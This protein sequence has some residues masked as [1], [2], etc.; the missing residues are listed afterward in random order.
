MYGHDLAA[1]ERRIAAFGW[2]TIVINGHDL[3]QIDAA[4]SRAPR[5]RSTADDHCQN[6]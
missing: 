6:V 3:E 1:Y 4:F 5:Y 2:K